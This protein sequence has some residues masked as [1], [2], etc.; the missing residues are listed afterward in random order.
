MSPLLLVLTVV[1]RPTEQLETERKD[2]WRWATA[3]LKLLAE[4]CDE[5]NKLSSALR[6][7]DRATIA[8]VGSSSSEAQWVRDD[9]EMDDDNDD[10]NDDDYDD[11]HRHGS[12]VFG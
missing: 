4:F 9:Q 6:F 5:E 8:A 2:R 12:I 11:D 10:D 3:R 1:L 7:G